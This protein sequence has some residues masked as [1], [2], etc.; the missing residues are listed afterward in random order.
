MG[1]ERKTQWKTPAALQ[2]KTSAQTM[3]TKANAHFRS[4]Q[5]P[6]SHKTAAKLFSFLSWKITSCQLNVLLCP[7]VTGTATKELL[8]LLFNPLI[9][10]LDELAENVEKLLFPKAQDNILTCILSTT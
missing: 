2:D 10:F 1:D 3:E 9:I 7:I 5:H 8:L 4:S 6:K